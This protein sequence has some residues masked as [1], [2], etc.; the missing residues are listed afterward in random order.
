MT[1]GHVRPYFPSFI[2]GCSR[3]RHPQGARSEPPAVAG[4]PVSPAGAVRNSP[5]A[6]AGGS[7]RFG[8]RARL[9]AA[10]LPTVGGKICKA[11]GE[12]GG[13]GLRTC[14]R[15]GQNVRASMVERC[16]FPTP[17]HNL[18]KSLLQAS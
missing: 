8:G 3:M 4:G 18:V 9:N 16:D 6:T 2:A 14:K 15:I 17:S 5:P 13:F 12:Q 11:V 1:F 7:D 10:V